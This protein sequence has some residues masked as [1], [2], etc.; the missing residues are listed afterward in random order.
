MSNDAKLK[1]RTKLYRCLAQHETQIQPR[2][3]VRPAS[4]LAAQATASPEI[5]C[6]AFEVDR[7]ITQNIQVMA[8]YR[9]FVRFNGLRHNPWTAMPA[10]TIRSGAFSSRSEWN[11]DP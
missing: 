8:Q 10:A 6:Y 3:T 4:V 11:E 9:G 2:G 1:G 5:T 7:K